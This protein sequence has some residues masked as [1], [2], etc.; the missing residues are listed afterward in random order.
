MLDNES[1]PIPPTQQLSERTLRNLKEDRKPGLSDCVIVIWRLVPYQDARF[2][3][4]A[5]LVDLTVIEEFGQDKDLPWSD[6]VSRDFAH[7]SLSDGEHIYNSARSIGHLK[8]QL[9]KL[10]PKVV[11]IQGWSNPA[12]YA[13]ARWALTN[14]S[15]IIVFSESNRYD[16]SRVPWIEWVKAQFLGVCDA[17]LV[18]GRD[19][20][21][22]LVDLRF[23]SDRVVL[24]Y[25]V[26]DN[27]HFAPPL[28]A[29]EVD[30]TRNRVPYFLVVCRL[31]EIKNVEHVIRAFAAY[32]LRVKSNPWDLVLVGIGHLEGHLRGLI[33]D[34]RMDG[35]VRLEGFRKYHELPTVY[36]NAGALVHA[37]TREPWGLVVNEAMASGL[38]VIV[39]NRCGC[40][41][42][43]VE[44]GVN[45]LT[46]DPEDSE[47]LVDHMFAMTDGSIDRNSFG[48]N[49][50]RIIAD[51]GPARFG[52]GFREAVEI[53]QRSPSRINILNRIVVR[54]LAQRK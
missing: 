40:C 17:A 43:L 16:H 9:D 20:I 22:Y 53:A 26:V 41:C 30:S 8:A 14:N 47:S 12:A 25:D 49:S 48:S 4:A 32:R 15:K 10:A 54:A 3:A 35:H 29:A 36:H 50:R 1:H 46:F 42:E 2:S 7:I 51:W 19:H 33:A 21:D 38:P 18:G 52:A 13:T 39:S 23:D 11:A 37:S 24:G 31:T 5:Q 44:D 28:P 45:G 34:L 27:D 6:D